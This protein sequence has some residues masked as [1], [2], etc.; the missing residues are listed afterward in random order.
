MDITLNMKTDFQMMLRKL[1]KHYKPLAA[2][3]RELDLHEKSLQVACRTKG[4]SFMYDTG[5]KI[6]DLYEAHCHD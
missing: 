3:A 2:I 5:R 4:K 6:V 1:R